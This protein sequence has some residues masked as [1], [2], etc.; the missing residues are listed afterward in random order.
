MKHYFLLLILF[1]SACNSQNQLESY[2]EL[3]SIETSQAIYETFNFE[4]QER[5]LDTIDVNWSG[6]R[7]VTFTV[8]DSNEGEEMLIAC[9]SRFDFK[10]KNV[11][12]SM[13]NFDL[14][15]DSIRYVDTTFLEL[16]ETRKYKVN[17]IDHEVVKEPRSVFNK[18]RKPNKYYFISIDFGLIAFLTE[19]EQSILV[20]YRNRK[21]EEAELKLIE[22]LINDDFF[23]K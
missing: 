14:L 17:S 23:G 13:L 16:G 4:S 20:G 10:E 9:I 22:S 2:K 5:S 7:L 12:E 6:D 8:N 18:S 1:L 11:S 3:I 15:G 19:K 21:L